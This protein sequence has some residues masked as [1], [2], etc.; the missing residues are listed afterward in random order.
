MKEVALLVS[1]GVESCILAG[2]LSQVCRQVKPIYVKFGLTWEESELFH[3]KRY[4]QAIAHKSLAELTVLEM[5]A[6]DVYQNHWSQNGIDVPEAG[7]PDEAVYLPGRNILLTA[8]TAV[9]CAL[10]N[11]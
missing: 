10:N 1:G 3:L 7:T 4:L 5:P 8:K 9:W 11:L 6:D 2:L